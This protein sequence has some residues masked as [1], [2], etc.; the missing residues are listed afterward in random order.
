[1]D[2]A[3]KSFPFASVMK[4]NNVHGELTVICTDKDAFL[5]PETIEKE[6]DLV[7]VDVF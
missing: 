3:P 4:K 7:D 5:T 2:E 1:M 6:P